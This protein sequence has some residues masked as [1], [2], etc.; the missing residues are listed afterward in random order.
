MFLG[1]GGFLADVALLLIGAFQT[2]PSEAFVRSAGVRR[3]G[4]RHRS[5]DR[6]LA[7][8]RRSLW[9]DVTS[10]CQRARIG[11]SAT[12]ALAGALILI[13]VVFPMLSLAREIP[14]HLWGHQ[15]KVAC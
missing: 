7:A 12:V 9:S 4:D 13:L 11:R 15:P 5:P 1:L 10:A 14:W 3:L 8:R 6:V 2:A